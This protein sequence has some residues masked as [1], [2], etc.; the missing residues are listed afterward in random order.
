MRI[1]FISYEFPPDTGKGGIGTYTYQ[2]ATLLAKKGI[3]V[4]VFAGSNY[5]TETERNDKLTI[6][7]IHSENPH[8][9]RKEVVEIFETQHQL[10][11][12]DVIESPEIHSN[13]LEVKKRFP[14]LPLVV[15]L[16]APNCLVEHLK[17][18][19]IPFTAK[20]RFVLGALRRGRWDLGY[21]RPYNKEN[22]P[23]YQF[24]NNADYV[25]APSEAMRTWVA[26]HWRLSSQKVYVLPN[27]FIPPASLLEIPIRGSNKEILFYG[28]LNVLKGCV[29]L[30]Y[31]IRK[32]LKRYPDWKVTIIGEN[33]AGPNG[34]GTMLDWMKKRLKA[35]NERIE[36]RASISYHELPSAIAG[37]SIIVLPSLFESFSY[38]CAEAM[39]AGKAIVGSREGGMSDLLK[40]QQSGSLVNPYSFVAIARSIERYIEENEL[41]LNAGKKA[42][43]S[44]VKMSVD[45]EE[46]Y[47]RYYTNLHVEKPV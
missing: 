18:T 7:R 8:T 9:F 34:V 31:A 41:R 21:W 11:P 12:F 16:H 14:H 47:V 25:T 27:P 26:K 20:M 4:H 42:R 32:V 36:F 15:R 3:E 29:N 28:R 39:A 1:A 38:V 17:N 33:G 13:A 6:H 43:E 40:D 24:V 19:Y 30:T 2:T 5:R 44:I 45:I 10:T 22:D 35:Y 23:D 46:K 37:A